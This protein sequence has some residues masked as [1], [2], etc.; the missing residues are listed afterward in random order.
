MTWLPAKIVTMRRMWDDGASAAEIGRAIGMT[1]NAVL[2]KVHRLGMATHKTKANGGRPRKPA[3]MTMTR[4][5]SLAL[6][7][8]TPVETPSRP[9]S[10]MELGRDRCRFPIGDALEPATVFCGAVPVYDRPY[11][12]AHCRIAYRAPGLT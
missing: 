5:P 7:K 9:C 4:A 3:R 11:C 6:P 2:G 8:P 12:L 10:I 1:R